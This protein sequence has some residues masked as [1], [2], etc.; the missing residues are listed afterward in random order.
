[1]SLTPQQER[2]CL[3]YDPFDGGKGDDGV[4][5]ILFDRIVTARKSGDCCIC[6]ETIQPGERSRRQV[7]IVDGA[8]GMWRI[9]EAC[10]A[11]C[12]A[13]WN[14]AGEAI[15]ERTAMGMRK[16]GALP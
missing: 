8:L 14:D 5:R 11:A 15:S 16:A 12:A 13:S 1:M 4:E 2:D 3:S 10:C 6:F 7:A 9:C